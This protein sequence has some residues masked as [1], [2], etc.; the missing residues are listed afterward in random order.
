MAQTGVASQ[1]TSG[2]RKAPEPISD[3]AN[4]VDAD[5]VIIGAGNAGLTAAAA[6]LDGG[7]KVVLLEAKDEVQDSRSWIGAVDS[8]L[9]KARGGPCRH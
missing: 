7:A 8:K 2:W 1:D 5:I 3:V 4:T 6:A 9:Q